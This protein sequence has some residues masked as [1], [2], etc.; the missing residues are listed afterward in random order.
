MFRFRDVG[1]GVKGLEFSGNPW[2][3]YIQKPYYTKE[4]RT[5]EALGFKV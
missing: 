2:I 5:I 4:S 1:F 3:H